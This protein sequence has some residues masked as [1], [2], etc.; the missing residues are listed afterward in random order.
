MHDSMIGSRNWG[1]NRG[2]Q[3]LRR[4]R[5]LWL[6]APPPWPQ[7]LLCWFGAH[8]PWPPLSPS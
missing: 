5:T 6:G 8:L 1:E 7:L 4:G 2:W 3:G